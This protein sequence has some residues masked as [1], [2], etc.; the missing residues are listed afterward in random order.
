MVSLT[1]EQVSK[2][3]FV[4]ATGSGVSERE[5]LF[6]VQEFREPGDT[7]L[8]AWNWLQWEDLP[9]ENSNAKIRGLPSP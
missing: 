3:H 7:T 1:G 9:H 8:V 2:P 5:G 4:G 6:D